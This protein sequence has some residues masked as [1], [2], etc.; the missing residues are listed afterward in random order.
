L[1]YITNQINPYT[2]FLL[3]YSIFNS[4]TRTLNGCAEILLKPVVKRLRNLKG[5]TFVISTFGTKIRSF[6]SWPINSRNSF[7]NCVQPGGFKANPL[8]QPAQGCRWWRHSHSLADRSRAEML[9]VCG[10]CVQ[11]IILSRSGPRRGSRR[12]KRPWRNALCMGW[13]WVPPRNVLMPVC[14]CGACV[15][16][17]ESASQRFYTYAAFFHKR[18]H[19]CT[20]IGC[21]VAAKSCRGKMKMTVGQLQ[22][23]FRK[24]ALTAWN[25]FSSGQQ[26]QVLCWQAH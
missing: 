7:H 13:P 2:K 12:L 16:S 23:C 5:L 17:T 20:Q 6:F 25:I 4:F 22:L 24:R 21:F 9:F 14:V 26:A 19:I 11:G 10:V 15:R 3:P 1:S 18:I 8:H